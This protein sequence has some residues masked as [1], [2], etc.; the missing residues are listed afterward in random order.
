MH[1]GCAEYGVWP[2]RPQHTG[3]YAP[4]LLS[5][6]TRLR[7]EWASRCRLCP[8][9]SCGTPGT[10]PTCCVAMSSSA[11]DTH[12]PTGAESPSQHLPQALCPPPL[13]SVGRRTSG[14]SG[15]AAGSRWRA[16][17]AYGTAGSGARGAAGCCW[18]GRG[19]CT[20]RA[21]P[22]HAPRYT[23]GKR[24]GVQRGFC[25]PLVGPS[26]LGASLWRHVSV[27]TP[28]PLFWGPTQTR[29]PGGQIQLVLHKVWLA[30]PHWATQL[31]AHGGKVLIHARMNISDVTKHSW[32]S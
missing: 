11:R 10:G 4:A 27:L 28:M 12:K 30:N 6:Q 14:L 19:P 17:S 31:P 2:R 26:I 3:R 24:W 9:G 18:V 1:T 20:A 5:S 8:T 22:S 7:P 13:L 16:D 32:F 15:A 29:L 23:C 25:R 21:A